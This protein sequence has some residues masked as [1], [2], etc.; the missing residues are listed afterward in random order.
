[1]NIEQDRALRPGKPTYPA[2]LALE[3]FAAPGAAAIAVMIASERGDLRAEWLSKLALASGIE[4]RGEPLDASCL[5]TRVE[6]Y[7]PDV[8]LLDKRLLDRL[9][10]RSLQRIHA[11][12]RHVRVLLLCDELCRDLVADVLRHRFHGFLLGTCPPEVCLKAL[13]AVRRG[14][15]WLSR[16]L[17]AKVITDPNWP[18]ATAG[19]G[20]S[21]DPDRAL[22]MDTLTQRELQ[23]VARLHL[24]ASNKEIA[25]DLGIMEDTVKKH[26]KSIFAKLGVRRRA[27]L[28]LLAPATSRP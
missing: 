13:R 12:A 18:V 4:L 9:D 11:Q 3:H 23:V 16:Q 2:V 6:R 10:R 20:A 21:N 26:L 22:A 7:Q 8:L 15:L 14:E 17:M 1:M 24:G 19:A 5:A 27:S 25:R 28:L